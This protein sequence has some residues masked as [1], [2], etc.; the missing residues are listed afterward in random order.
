MARTCSTNTRCVCKIR[1]PRHWSRE[2][3]FK[4]DLATLVCSMAPPFKSPQNWAHCDSQS[5]M[6]SRWRWS[7]P[8]LLQP[9]AS[10]VQWSVFLSAKSTTPLTFIVSYAKCMGH[11]VWI[12]ERAKVG[13]RVRVW[14]YKR[15]WWTAFWSTFGFSQNNSKVEQEQEMLENRCVTVLEL[16]ERIPEVG[17][18]LAAWQESSMTRIC[19]KCHRACKR[20]SITMVITSKNSW[21]SKLSINVTFILCEKNWK[22]YFADT[23]RR[24]IQKSIQSFSCMTWGDK[25]FREAETQMGG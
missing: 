12:S 23:H 17:V 16:C 3:R 21:K 10:W 8:L 4:Q 18:R 1:S 25:T 13:Q 2:E 5:W 7:S 24:T 11:S 9:G 6:G 19:G 20:A 14:M 15:P 22:L